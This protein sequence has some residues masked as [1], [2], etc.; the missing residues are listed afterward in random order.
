M[1]VTKCTIR[2]PHKC[3]NTCNIEY[4]MKPGEYINILN[5]F[6]VCDLKLESILTGAMRGI[7]LMTLTQHKQFKG[8]RIDDVFSDKARRIYVYGPETLSGQLIF[9]LAKAKR[10][11]SYNERGE[12]CINYTCT[13]VTFEE[14]FGTLD[15]AI[16]CNFNK[17]KWHSYDGSLIDAEVTFFM[18][19]PCMPFG[20]EDELERATKVAAIESEI[21]KLKKQRNELDAA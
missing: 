16:L 4:R 2:T 6:A 11:D 5:T 1:T 18:P 13:P 3:P 14:G 15:E 7:D 21:E 8:M 19:L 12:G 20:V 10:F 9:V 17:R